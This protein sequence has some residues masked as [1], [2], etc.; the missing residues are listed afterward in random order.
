MTNA[1]ATIGVAATKAMIPVTEELEEVTA[2]QEDILAELDKIP[3][4]GPD[5]KAVLAA[6][7]RKIP[8][9]DQVWFLDDLKRQMGEKRMDFLTQREEPPIA[10]PRKVPPTKAPPP[11]KVPPPKKVTPPTEVPPTKAPPPSE[12]VIPKLE[13]VEPVEPPEPE[14]FT[15][16]RTAPTVL[17]P[18]LER[19][20]SAPPDVIEEIRREL[21]KIPGLS[22][23]EKAALVDHLKYLSKE[24]RQTTYWSLKQTTDMDE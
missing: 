1:M 17:P 7:M 15:K 24:E 4:L 20:P 12:P 13:E 22:P 19:K 9:K 16:D 5:E 21:D 11:E 2:T 23:E 8:R 3:G 10:K 6:E 14:V 18:E